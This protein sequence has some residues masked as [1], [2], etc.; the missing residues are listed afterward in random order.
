MEKRF[1]QARPGWFR[2]FKRLL[3]FIYKK[4]RF[5]YLGEPLGNGGIILSNHVG[6]HAPLT[7]ELYCDKPIRFWGA[8]TLASWI[9][10]LSRLL[11]RKA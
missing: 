1:R 2:A 5:A 7:L 8:M 11:R 10:M 4:P 9:R 3:V 6:S